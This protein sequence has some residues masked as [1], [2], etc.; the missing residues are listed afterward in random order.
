MWRAVSQLPTR[1]RP[2]RCSHGKTRRRTTR[3]TLPDSFRELPLA[4]L[5]IEQDTLNVFE[6]LGIQSVKQLLDVPREQ[7]IG[8]YGREFQKVID[9]IEQKGGRLLAPNV[10]ENRVSWEYLLDSPVEDFEQLIFILNHGLDRL[11]RQV[12]HCGFST[13]H[14]DIIFGLRNKTEKSYEIKTSF[15]TL[16]RPFWLKLINL[17]L[18]LDPPEA[19]IVSVDVVSHFTKPRPE[20]RGLYAVSRPEPESLLLT[21][22]KLKKL[23][24]EENVG[25]P[26]ILNQRMAEPFALD[27]DAMPQGI[28]RIEVRQ[29][30]VN[31]CLQLFS[32]AAACRSDRRGRQFV[33]YPHQIFQRPCK[34]I[35]RR[36]EEKFQM[37]GRS[38]ENTG[39]G[40]RDRRQGIYRLCR[41]RNEWFVVGEY[42]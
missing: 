7:L 3:C 25:V 42:D 24:G 28:E 23:V 26:V 11:F 30:K 29:E 16:E 41:I 20:Q 10:K 22:N 31:Y 27:A 15:P 33:I 17:R 13:E 38:M 8:R 40:R 6:D 2:P 34:R 5:P 1:S 32:P 36:L 12:A 9:V 39:M 21:V 37:V 19:G 35:Q 14:L 18:S 4:D